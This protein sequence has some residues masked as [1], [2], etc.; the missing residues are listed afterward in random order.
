MISFFFFFFFF[1]FDKGHQI[2]ILEESEGL[3]DPH[4]TYL[5]KYYEGPDF[6]IV[7]KGTHVFY[8]CISYVC[9]NLKKTFS[10]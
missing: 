8:L 9:Y 5:P 3:N 4:V 1:F 7:T 6:P 2:Q 10:K